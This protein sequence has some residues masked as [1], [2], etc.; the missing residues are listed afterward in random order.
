MMRL[1]SYPCHMHGVTTYMIG[2]FFTHSARP[3]PPNVRLNVR[4]V[5]RVI[6]LT[7]YFLLR[8][9]ETIFQLPVDDSKVISMTL[10]LNYG[11]FRRYVTQEEV[12]EWKAAFDIDPVKEAKKN[13]KVSFV[14]A[15]AP[16]SLQS[17]QWSQEKPQDKFG[18]NAFAEWK[19]AFDI[20]PVKEAKKNLWRL[21]CAPFSLRSS[22]CS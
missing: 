9:R 10:A 1:Q 7:A 11:K 5:C 15:G 3:L 6:H 2:W 13:L 16:F 12:A 21:T 14:S 17:N 19:A 4:I 8:C 18:Y 22:Q 20:D